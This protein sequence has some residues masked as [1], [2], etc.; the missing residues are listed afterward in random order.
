MFFDKL[1]QLREAPEDVKVHFVKM[2]TIVTVGIITVIWFFFA[3]PR[4][5]AVG[6]PF[7]PAATS[8]PATAATTSAP[9]PL[10]APF[11]SSN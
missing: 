4:F 10:Q 5:L 1:D 11:P 8:T 2:A 3:L 7:K 9:V 6:T